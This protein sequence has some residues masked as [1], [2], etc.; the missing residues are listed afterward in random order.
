MGSALAALLA[1][2]GLV[3]RG[4]EVVG[5]VGGRSGAAA[6]GAGR[7]VRGGGAVLTGVATAA[8]T[9]AIGAGVGRGLGGLGG[10]LLLEDDLLLGDLVEQRAEPHAGV[11][12]GN[13]AALGLE[14]GLTGGLLGLLLG[15][16]LG[17]LLGSA[18]SL[19]GG[20][21]LLGQ[22]AL[23]LATGLGGEALGLLL[24]SGLGLG[25]ALGLLLGALS[26]LDL[27]RTGLDHGG[28][29]L[30]DHGDEGVLEGGR[31][32]LRR[33]LHLFKVAHEF[34]GRHAELFGQAGN[35]DFRHILHLP[36]TRTGRASSINKNQCVG[37]RA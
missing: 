30:L 36:L 22:T 19:S 31:R 1:L 16:A 8:T 20:L 26:G 18:G 15:A 34:L 33:D 4:R 6:T 14:L 2:A 29:L 32:G 24:G 10:L 37:T 28:E 21:S 5:H 9:A 3:G 11:G 12:R 23:L 13:G 25:G 35:T 27:G 17:L 7:S